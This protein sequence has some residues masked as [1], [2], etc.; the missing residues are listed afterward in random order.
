[1]NDLPQNELLSAYLDGELTAAEQADVERLLA[2][3][4][5][6]RQL[7]DE[8]RTLS[9]TL[10][11]LP[12][13]KLGEDLSQQVLQ[14]AEH[15]MLTEGEPGEAS[16]SPIAPVPLGRSVFQRFLTRRTMV[17]LSL[18]AAIAIMIVI[19]EHRRAVQPENTV[20]EVALAPGGHEKLERRIGP[21]TRPARP[22]SKPFA[23]ILRSSRGTSRR[24]WRE[25]G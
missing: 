3:S 18:T 11:A 24:A 14:I 15:R 4:P 10:Q 6:A 19:D 25:E 20:C 1:M 21:R 13:Q 2:A 8:L 12:Q 5:A 22:L 16:A 23:T 7:L 17:W 9:A